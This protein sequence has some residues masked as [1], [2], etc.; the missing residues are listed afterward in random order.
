MPKPF[1]KTVSGAMRGAISAIA[2]VCGWI[3]LFHVVIAF[4]QQWVL[5]YLPE[6]VQVIVCGILELT[7]GCLML[8]GIADQRM[9]FLLAAVMLNFGGFCVMIQTRSLTEG[10]D[11]RG[12]LYG[13][14][15]Q[16]LFSI[17]YAWICLGHFWPLIPL[18]CIFLFRL[19]M[20]ARKKDSISGKLVV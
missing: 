7:N 15:L 6:T 4:F 17:L 2:T 16:T 10:L 12:Y 11:F 19:S 9:R 18:S 3:V 14:C 13:K 1:A 8:S 5:W 20:P